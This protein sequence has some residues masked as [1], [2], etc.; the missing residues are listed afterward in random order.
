[1]SDNT[2][3]TH[4]ELE[5]I[6]HTENGMSL[7]AIWRA[8]RVAGLEEAAQTIERYFPDPHTGE[9]ECDNCAMIRTLAAFVRAR[10]GDIG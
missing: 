6:F 2:E 7:L 8:G 1:M 10:L 3:P 9:E 4:D 5:A